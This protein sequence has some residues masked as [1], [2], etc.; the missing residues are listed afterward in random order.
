MIG[1]HDMPT[2][3]SPFRCGNIT[4]FVLTMDNLMSHETQLS[5]SQKFRLGSGPLKWK[6]FVE[7]DLNGFLNFF[8]IT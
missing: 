2:L 7:I 6:A 1:E 4:L 3:Q 5:L 8:N